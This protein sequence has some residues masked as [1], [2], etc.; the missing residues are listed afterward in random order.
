[1]CSEVRSKLA[2][3]LPCSSCNPWS[4]NAKV[5]SFPWTLPENRGLFN[6]PLSFACKS[7]WPPLFILSP[8]NAPMREMSSILMASLPSIAVS[9]KLLQPE[10]DN[11]RGNAMLARVVP[12]FLPLATNSPVRMPLFTWLVT[13]NCSKP[14][15]NG[16]SPG[17][18]QSPFSRLI[19]KLP[20]N[21]LAAF[22]SQSPPSSSVPWVF[23]VL[24]PWRK[25]MPVNRPWVCHLSGAHWVVFNSISPLPRDNLVAFSDAWF[26]LTLSCVAA[27]KLRGRTPLE[28][29]SVNLPAQ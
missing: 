12:M 15:E 2:S 17:R 26:L 4:N 3:S 10:P 8:S 11:V 9:C 28:D 16:N 27:C 22:T 29:S 20:V 5:K 7:S 14:N 24:L 23:S 6:V 19:C 21:C 13:C 18:I 1:M 25:E